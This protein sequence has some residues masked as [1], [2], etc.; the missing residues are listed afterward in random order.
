MKRRT[1]VGEINNGQIAE[2]LSREAEN[3]SYPIQR[4]LRS[5]GR[6]AFLRTE[7]A[8]ALAAQ[9]RSLTELPKVGP[10]LEKQIL[11]WLAHPPA[12]VEEVPEIRRGFLTWAEELLKWAR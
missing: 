12:A 6:A 10:I 8:S 3:A 7:E 2:W 9:K 4:A 11:K 1:K 5:A